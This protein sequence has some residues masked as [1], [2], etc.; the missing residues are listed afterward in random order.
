MYSAVHHDRARGAPEHAGQLV[1]PEHAA[2]VGVDA[3]QRAF[4]VARKDEAAAINEFGDRRHLQC[5]IDQHYSGR[6]HGDGA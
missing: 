4:V 5:R 2:G 1:L 3:H 6:K